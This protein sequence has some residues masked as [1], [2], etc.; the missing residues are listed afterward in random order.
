MPKTEVRFVETAR[1][2]GEPLVATHLPGLLQLFQ[3][4]RVTP[5]LT[6]TG[7]PLSDADVENMVLT[8]ADHWEKHG[9]G[10][11]VFLEK[12]TGAF[13]GRG[14]LRACVIEECET[15][16]VGYALL[17]DYWGRGLATEMARKSVDVAFSTLNLP[18]L[19]CFTL[20]TN[21][22]SQRVMQKAGFVFDKPIIYANLPHLLFRLNNP[23]KGGS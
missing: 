13:V 7:K 23:A 11:W 2:R 16:E 15:V 14:G 9:W 12:E 6:A 1:L 21:F 3:D 20:T 17:P 10:P 4:E 22:A 8:A 18:A 19:V 5:T